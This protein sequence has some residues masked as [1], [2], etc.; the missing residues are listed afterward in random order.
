MGGAGC[1]S[2]L[3]TVHRGADSEDASLALLGFLTG[4]DGKDAADETNGHPSVS[5][6]HRE[7][8]IKE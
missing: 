8:H 7:R 5:R 1:Y 2:G 4:D 3:L 6:V